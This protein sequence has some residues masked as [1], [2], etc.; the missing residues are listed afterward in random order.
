MKHS[1]KGLRKISLGWQSRD[2][3]YTVADQFAAVVGCQIATT[4]GRGVRAT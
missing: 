2:A 3:S 1:G 4:D